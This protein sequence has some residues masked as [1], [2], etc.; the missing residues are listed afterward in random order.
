[1]EMGKTINERVD[2][3]CAAYYAKTNVPPEEAELV[4][5]YTATGM[6]MYIR[7]RTT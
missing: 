4:V 3:L 7:K 1:M 5:E 6:R 2:E